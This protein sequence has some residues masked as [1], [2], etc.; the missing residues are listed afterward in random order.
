M[1]SETKKILRNHIPTAQK[2]LTSFLA[3]LDSDVDDTKEKVY[4]VEILKEAR[5]NINGAIDVLQA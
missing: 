2:Y 5:Q 3:C 1:N 4:L